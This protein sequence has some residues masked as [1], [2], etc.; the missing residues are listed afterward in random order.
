MTHEIVCEW[1]GDMAFEAE[2][3]G[4]R[5]TLDAEE[6]FGGRNAGPRPKQLLLASLAGCSGMDVISILR[7]MRE[8]VSWY[9]IKVSGELTEEHPKYYSRIKLVYRFKQA[10]GLK[11]EN[12]EKAV[13][14][15]QEKYCGVS[16]LLR[17]AIP[18]DWEIE[19]V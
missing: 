3:T 17:M 9:D 6:Q 10:D 5:I 19:Y 1:K 7:K 4:H 14:L 11:A 18:V 12:V 13:R 8:P 2:V 15:S 16:A